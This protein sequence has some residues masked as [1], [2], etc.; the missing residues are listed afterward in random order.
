MDATLLGILQSANFLLPMLS[1]A[2]K[3]LDT[4]GSDWILAPY[5]A[6]LGSS[7]LPSLSSMVNLVVAFLA[8]AFNMSIM[9]RRNYG[10]NDEQENY[11]FGLGYSNS[12]WF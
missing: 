7:F 2:L 12:S 9:I 8:A 4:K 3:Y 1:V 6:L 5:R 11:G 10:N